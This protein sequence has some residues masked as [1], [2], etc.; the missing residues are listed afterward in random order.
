MDDTA[1]FY[2]RTL[3]IIMIL[4]I[5]VPLVVIG[6]LLWYFSADR[7]TEPPAEQEATLDETVESAATA[8]SD[9]LGEDANPLQPVGPKASTRLV[10]GGTVCPND[11]KYGCDSCG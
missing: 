8:Q 2:S 11:G 3:R 1:F 7:G 4:A 6:G 5:V 9:G 10:P